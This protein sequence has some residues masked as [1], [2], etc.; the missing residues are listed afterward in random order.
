MAAI[1]STAITTIETLTTVLFS[2]GYNNIKK[3]SGRKVAVLTDE[4]RVDVL[5][6]I[7]KA[8]SGSAY[9]RT[10]SSESSVGKVKIGLFNVLVKPLSKQ[11]KASA[12]LDNEDFLVDYV[13]SIIKTLGSVNIVFK[14][15]T[16]TYVINN[17]VS[18]AAVGG[19]TKG[20][21]KADV[22]F[23]NNARIGFPVSIKKDNAE[24]WESA[25]SYFSEEAK[26]IIDNAVANNKT[27]LV[28]K[29]THFNIEPNIAVEATRQEKLDVVFGADLLPN[30]AVI[31]RTFSTG[32]F[33]LSD[34]TLTIT[35]S[36]IITQANDIKGDKDVFFLI[37]N[38]KTR[39]SIME[40]PGIRI[41]AVYKKRINPKVVV[42]KR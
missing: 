32:D 12:G 2:I 24:I 21:K 37:R 3:I 31:T 7:Q 10:P 28:N 19:D 23:R 40:Y 33:S 6:K 39:R 5:V 34:E 13:N 16:K 8:I 18:V 1:K 25:D 17:C 26:R 29:G 27:S 9:D 38:D 42:V 41:L 30:G 20:R 35:V 11:G 4:N 15:N 14:H 36:S 22:M